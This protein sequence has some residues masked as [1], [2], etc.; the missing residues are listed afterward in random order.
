[1]V[2][3]REMSRQRLS[4]A[5]GRG[6]WHDE[7]AAVLEERV[8]A[9]EPI[10]YEIVDIDAHD[11][12]KRIAPFDLVIWKGRFLGPESAGHYKD[13]VYFMERVLGKRVMPSFDTVWSFDSKVAQHYLLSYLDVPTPR[14]IV[15]FDYDHARRLLDK[16]RFPVVAKRSY[17]ASSSNVR[18]LKNPR[19]ARRWLDSLFFHEKWMRHK[20]AHPNVLARVLTT[21][22]HSWFLPKVMERLLRSERHSVAYWQEY[23]PGN[24]A[25][26]RIAVIGD[27]AAYG[28]WRHNRPGDF[29]ASGSGLIDYERLVP[30][31]VVEYCIALNRRLG[32][33]SMAYDIL[34][35]PEGMVIV[36]MSYAYVD[37]ALFEAPGHFVL[38]KTQTLVY[39]E[40]HVMPQDLW[41]DWAI[42]KASRSS[43]AGA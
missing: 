14:T 39:Q 4:I 36:E 27:S 22:F 2:E 29:R 24:E 19:H 6:V 43:S 15:A 7:F 35:G 3:S 25:D 28:F 9:G 33:D 38:D 16:E 12:Q 13:K 41:V 18:L 34:F 42:R 37:K 5:I 26:L 8:R 30:H 10:A 20:A 11:W 17:G 40:G 23:L 31:E 21:P 32:F 1:L